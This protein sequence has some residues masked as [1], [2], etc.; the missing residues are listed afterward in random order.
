MKKQF[1]VYRVPII[2]KKNDW[3][4]KKEPLAYELYIDEQM[5]NKKHPKVIIL[6]NLYAYPQRN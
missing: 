5:E 2:D 1:D 3:R 6:K 4:E